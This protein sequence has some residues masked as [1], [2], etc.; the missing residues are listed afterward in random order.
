MTLTIEEE[1]EEE[2]EQEEQEEEEEEEGV[3]E[4]DEDVLKDRSVSGVRLFSYHSN[5]LVSRA[6]VVWS[7]HDG[8]DEE[9][10]SDDT[11]VH[12]VLQRRRRRRRTQDV[13]SGLLRGNTP[14]TLYQFR[15]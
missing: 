1:E 11:G 9:Q 13:V 2:E 10:H 15:S 5:V 4:E 7:K 14:V 8:G 12:K 3:N 6:A